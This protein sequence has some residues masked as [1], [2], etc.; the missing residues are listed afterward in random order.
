MWLTKVEEIWNSFYCL[1]FAAFATRAAFNFSFLFVFCCWFSHHLVLLLSE[2]LLWISILYSAETHEKSQRKQFKLNFLKRKSRKEMEKFCK[3]AF[4]RYFL[5]LSYYK[6]GNA[7]KKFEAWILFYLLLMKVVKGERFRQYFWVSSD[8]HQL[9]Y[10][11]RTWSARA[12]FRLKGK[13]E[14]MNIIIN[15]IPLVLWVFPRL[16]LEYWTFTQ[17]NSNSAVGGWKKAYTSWNFKVEK[18]TKCIKFPVDPNNIHEIEC[19]LKSEEKKDNNVMRVW[20]ENMRMFQTNN[21]NFN[22]SI[23]HFS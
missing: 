9:H 7:K 20:D 11:Y 18:S 23:V 4:M 3:R 13:V 16:L 10:Y 21:L 2:S 15:K 1:L 17:V 12:P 6:R 22:S 19:I 8:S 5:I 14:N